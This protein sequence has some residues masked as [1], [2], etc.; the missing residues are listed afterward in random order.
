MDTALS[1]GQLKQGRHLIRISGIIR[2]RRIPICF[3]PDSD[4]HDLPRVLV[5]LVAVSSHSA[6]DLLSMLCALAPVSG[7]YSSHSPLKHSVVCL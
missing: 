3:R 1:D 7:E 5:Q 2:H 4:K 6:V